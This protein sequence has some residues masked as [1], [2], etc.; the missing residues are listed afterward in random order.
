MTKITGSISLP[1]AGCGKKWMYVGSRARSDTSAGL[2][3]GNTDASFPEPDA[4]FVVAEG[5]SFALCSVGICQ[6]GAVLFRRLLFLCCGV[7]MAPAF[8]WETVFGVF[9]DVSETDVVLVERL[10][11]DPVLN[12]LVWM[13]DSVSSCKEDTAAGSC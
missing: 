1:S 6:S 7:R 10:V 3:A 5:R 2:A 13:A 12:A 4:V 9:K 8:F 11:C